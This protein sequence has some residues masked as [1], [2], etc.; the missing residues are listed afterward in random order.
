MCGHFTPTDYWHQ[1]TTHLDI[2]QPLFLQVGARTCTHPEAF[3]HLLLLSLPP[4]RCVALKP[5]TCRCTC[6]RSATL[7]LDASPSPSAPLPLTA[8]QVCG[9]ETDNMQVHLHEEHGPD[10]P[11]REIRRGIGSAVVVHRCVCGGGS[12]GVGG[13]GPV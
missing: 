11:H 8:F 5:T 10:G 13:A 4:F 9:I 2:W 7:H 6:V 12:A 3:H 1:C